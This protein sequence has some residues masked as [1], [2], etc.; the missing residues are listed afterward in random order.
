[1]TVTRSSS[2]ADLATTRPSGRVEPAHADLGGFGRAVHKRRH[3]PAASG[4]PDVSYQQ[5][6]DSWQEDPRGQPHR[7]GQRDLVRV[8]AIEGDRRTD[9]QRDLRGAYRGA[10]PAAPGYGASKAALNSFG[11]SDGR[12][13]APLRHRGRQAWRRDVGTEWPATDLN[14]ARCAEAPGAQSP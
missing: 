9:H 10:E 11:Q 4:H 1:V 13:L 3:L 7:R 8:P 2:G 6:Q 5:W 14:R 12:G